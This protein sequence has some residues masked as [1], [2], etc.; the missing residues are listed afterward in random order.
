[1]ASTYLT[2]TPSSAGNR[3]KWTW[4]AWIKLS[5]FAGSAGSM[6]LSA[7]AHGNDE[8]R[9]YF[10]DTYKLSMRFYNGSEYQQRLE[11]DFP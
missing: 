5:N 9:I 7:Y 2:R 4:S 11:L 10:G 8:F 6:L 3:Q 1:M